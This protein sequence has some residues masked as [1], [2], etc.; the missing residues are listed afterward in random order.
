VTTCTPVPKST[1][2]IACPS[3]KC[4]SGTYSGYDFSFS[5]GKGSTICLSASSL[6]AAGTTAA[7]D[8][9]TY[10][11]W[12]AGFGFNL[13]PDT[14]ATTTVEVQLAGAGVSVALSSLPTGAEARVQVT[15]GT[16]DYCAKMTTATQTLAWTSFNT[17]CW[18]NT[19][20]ALTAAPKTGKIQ[21]QASSGTAAGTFDFCV[22]SLSFQ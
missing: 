21:F 10:S 17:K 16:T 20:T 13:S 6:C 7:Q 1:G 11:V 4:T 9:P 18:D 5:D 12:G 2:G 3:G 14:T 19:G 22:T 15:V 8:P